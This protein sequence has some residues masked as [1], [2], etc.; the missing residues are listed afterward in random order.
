MRTTLDWYHNLRPALVR[1]RR[2]KK[3][4]L[5][6]AVGG[7]GV[8]VLI[9]V[10]ASLWNSYSEGSVIRVLGGVTSEQLSREIA[11]HPGPPGPAGPRGP[12]GP[13]GPPGDHTPATPEVRVVKLIPQANANY[14]KSAA[15]PRSEIYPVCTLSKVSLQKNSKGTAGSCELKRELRG[16]NG[17]EIIVT[18]ASCGV[19]CFSLSGAK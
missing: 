8:L 16:T 18:D 4:Y 17:W 9:A 6:G 11:A 2:V 19:T 1:M 15:I 3:S 12:V 14:V 7:L 5:E 10:G 13:A